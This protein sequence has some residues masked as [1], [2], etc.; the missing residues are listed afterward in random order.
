MGNSRRLKVP[1]RGWAPTGDELPRNGPR[2]MRNLLLLF[3]APPSITSACAFSNRLLSSRADSRLVPHG[4]LIKSE[5]AA[6]CATSALLSST[7]SLVS[8]TW[9]SAHMLRACVRTIVCEIYGEFIVGSDRAASAHSAKASSSVVMRVISYF[10][11]SAAVM[12][13]SLGRIY[14]IMS[15]LKRLVSL[16]TVPA[17]CYWG[18]LT[19]WYSIWPRTLS[20]CIQTVLLQ[21]A[22]PVDHRRF[23]W[24]MY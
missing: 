15:L 9:R 17:S 4:G 16:S 21:G 23:V 1:Q 18:W 5:N 8:S 14:V 7:R 3:S 20:N 19:G 12:D 22:S 11:D 13:C 10:S 6:V 2:S 24:F